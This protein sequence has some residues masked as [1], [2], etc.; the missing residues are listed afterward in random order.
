[1]ILC[2]SWLIHDYANSFVEVSFPCLAYDSLVWAAF[3]SG[4]KD[5]KTSAHSVPHVLSMVMLWSVY[6]ML[7]TGTVR[8]RPPIVSLVVSIEL[9]YEVCKDV[10]AKDRSLPSFRSTSFV[11][12]LASQSYSSTVVD[13]CLDS[14]LLLRML[15][16]PT[17]QMRCC[18]VSSSLHTTTLSPWLIADDLAY[19]GRLPEALKTFLQRC[20]DRQGY[21]S[22]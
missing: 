3:N 9:A 14:L 13:I 7:L 17:I 21:L 2:L 10:D 15:M 12:I 5:R 16:I 1:M 4:I 18:P 8:P 20:N 11:A 19:T 22:E 6:E